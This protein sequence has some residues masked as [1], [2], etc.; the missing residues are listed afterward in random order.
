MSDTLRDRCYACDGDKMDP[1]K[2]SRA[3]PTCKG[4]GEIDYCYT[5]GQAILCGG[6]DPNATWGFDGRPPRCLREGRSDRRTFAELTKIP[7]E[8]T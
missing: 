3:C 7:K 2:R 6:R 4:V 5:C 1:K 8:K